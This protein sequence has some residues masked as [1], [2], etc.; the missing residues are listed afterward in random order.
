[1]NV[2]SSFE[3]ADSQYHYMLQNHLR[4]TKQF[5]ESQATYC[6]PQQAH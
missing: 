2:N 5:T 6:M 4:L 3:K 1:V